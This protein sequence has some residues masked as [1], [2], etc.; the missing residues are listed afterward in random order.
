MLRLNVARDQFRKDTWV[1]HLYA[2][3]AWH[4]YQFVASSAPRAARLA[5]DAYSGDVARLVDK[6]VAPPA[7]MFHETFVSEEKYEYPH[8]TYTRFTVDG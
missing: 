4:I 2:P 8:G 5:L 3:D 7:P 6:I 1:V